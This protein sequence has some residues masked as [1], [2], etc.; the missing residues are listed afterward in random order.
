[1][2]F[3]QQQQPQTCPCHIS[4][5]LFPFSKLQFVTC[6]LFYWMQMMNSSP[7]RRAWLRGWITSTPH[8]SIVPGHQ[9]S[10]THALRGLSILEKKRKRITIVEKGIRNDYTTHYVI[11]FHGNH[12]L[13]NTAGLYCKCCRFSNNRWGVASYKSPSEWENIEDY[14]FLKIIYIDL[15]LNIN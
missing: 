9:S 11:I 3:L 8:P 13:A 6:N 5:F 15:L 12:V 4:L 1:M 2:K 14:I 10:K 7:P